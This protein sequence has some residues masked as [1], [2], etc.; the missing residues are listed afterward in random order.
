MTEGMNGAQLLVESLLANGVK[1][2]YGLVGIP[3]TDLARLMEL[4]GIDF[5]GFRREQYNPTSRNKKNIKQTT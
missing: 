4:K 5:Y 2:M 1:N 3:V